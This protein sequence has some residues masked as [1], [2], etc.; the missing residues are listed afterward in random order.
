MSPDL[1]M[2]IAQANEHIARL[3]A[4]AEH[5]SVPFSDGRAMH[6]RIFGQG[7]PLVLLH[8]GHGSW[9]H[10]IRNIDALSR[11]HMLFVPD[12]PGFGDSD[13][14]P[15][16]ASMQIARAMTDMAMGARMNA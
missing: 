12:L 15:A 3:D 8:G 9:L 1:P 2:D 4:A 6:W 11:D 16:E 7:N 13:D 5:R 14:P 10:W